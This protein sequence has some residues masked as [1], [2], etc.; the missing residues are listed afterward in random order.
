MKTVD[1]HTPLRKE[2]LF[3]KDRHTPYRK[4]WR[5]QKQN[6][7]T[8][9]RRRIWCPPFVQCFSHLAFFPFGAANTCSAH[10]TQKSPK[11]L[12][13]GL[14]IHLERVFLKKTE[15]AFF[16]RQPIVLYGRKKGRT[17]NCH[18]RRTPPSRLV[19]PSRWLFLNPCLVLPYT[20]ST[21]ALLLWA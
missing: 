18:P 10:K 17:G 20:Y 14:K 1:A 6:A 3:G 2:V 9:W 5:C 12:P 13:L 16:K 11:G 15:K 19:C 4:N 21:G 8:P 7:T